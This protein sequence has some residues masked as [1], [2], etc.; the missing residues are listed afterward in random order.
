MLL[1][2]SLAA[3][4]SAQE[5]VDVS[6]I[7]GAT[8]NVAQEVELRL[9]CPAECVSAEWTVEGDILRDYEL[10]PRYRSHDIEEELG[11]DGIPR[12]SLDGPGC[13]A[14]FTWRES[15]QVLPIDRLVRAQVPDGSCAA[16]ATFTVERNTD[17]PDRQFVDWWTLAHDETLLVEHQG[18]HMANG[19]CG[20]SY[21]GAL[22][23]SYHKELVIRYQEMGREFG[24]RELSEWDP[25]TPYP[26]V[27]D[28]FDATHAGR[29]QSSPEPVADLAAYYELRGAPDNLSAP[30]WMTLE[31]REGS[32]VNSLGEARESLVNC[33]PEGRTIA[34]LADYESLDEMACVITQ[35]YH[36]G[37]HIT[38]GGDMAT[39]MSPK[40]PIFY[41]WHLYFD[42]FV[43]D[44]ANQR[45]A[46]H[47]PEV[48]YVHPPAGG[49]VEGGAGAVVD[50]AATI[51]VWL[52]GPVTGMM[53]GML[54]VNGSPATEVEGSGQGPY[55]FSGYATAPE[56]MVD[57][58]LSGAAINDRGEQLVDFQYSLEVSSC[59]DDPD[60]DGMPSEFC[61]PYS[62]MRDN[63]P[64][65]YNP[66]QE[67]RDGDMFFGDACDPCPDTPLFALVGRPTSLEE[68]QAACAAGVVR[69]SGPNVYLATY[70]R[71]MESEGEVTISLNR[72]G[73]S[74]GVVEVP[75]TLV[76]VPGMVYAEAEPE[77]DYLGTSGVVTFEDG[78][79][80][81]AE[82]TIP[83]VADDVVE[84][85]EIFGVQW[86]QPEGG[87]IFGGI[88]F[89]I[90]IIED[91]SDE[92]GD[93]G[94]DPG[95]SDPGD[96]ADS[97][98]EDKKL[99]VPDGGCDGCSAERAGATHRVGTVAPLVGLAAFALGRRRRTA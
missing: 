12:A 76:S 47:P 37:V 33:L 2:C 67:D 90:V 43:N 74:T 66:D 16:E 10:L 77:L 1:F 7:P 58:V 84:G 44:W 85:V 3:T 30:P 23:L 95:D 94:P 63:C 53:P 31:G 40:D 49:P 34:T 26:D 20:P 98:A 80:S 72:A 48:A 60:G 75:Y 55:Y 14:T 15:G 65:D 17:D 99:L 22:F 32:S 35:P 5:I 87:A 61:W 59:T 13:T 36:R 46:E 52:T 29:L 4:A 71:V 21:R 50:Y 91:D 27:V 45:A 8:K 88:P 41:G 42:R 68:E 39:L 38:V 24:Y 82:L 11:G 64:D 69:L 96:T 9:Q 97:G 54:T 19:C 62:Y 6:P 51:E 70:P 92:G 93:T 81:S 18:S 25:A 78:Q 83:I 89:T 28:G 56:G 57:V 86:G 79:T 73:G